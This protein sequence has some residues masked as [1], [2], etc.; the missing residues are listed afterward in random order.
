MSNLNGYEIE[1]K[2]LICYPDTELLKA[3][4]G[5]KTYMFSQTY[6]S[7]GTRVRKSVSED[8]VKYIK[9]VKQQ[10]S[11][12]TRKETEWEIS[13]AEYKESLLTKIPETNTINKIRYCIPFDEHILEI[14]VFDFWDDRAFL[15][16]ELADENEKFSLPG[17]IK[18]IKE[19]TDDKR[20]RNSSLSKEII[21]ESIV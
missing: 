20:Y 16:I 17:Y 9:T 3:Q 6:T 10:V 7:D 19:V 8:E 12:I 21:N 2:F 5:C 13:E 11:N 15:E 4:D 14:D 18:I 1:R